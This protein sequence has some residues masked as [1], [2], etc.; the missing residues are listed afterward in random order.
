VSAEPLVVSAEP[1]VVSAEPLASA[2][3]REAGARAGEAECAPRRVGLRPAPA[4]AAPAHRALFG[5]REPRVVLGAPRVPSLVTAGVRPD[6]HTCFGPRGAALLSAN[7]PLWVA[8]R[9]IIVCWAGGAPQ[10]TMK[11][12]QTG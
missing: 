12:R 1:L 5:R 3:P 6:R 10:S 9:A 8:T 11:H 4:S 2:R 7:G